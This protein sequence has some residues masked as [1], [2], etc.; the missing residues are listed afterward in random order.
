LGS[1]GFSSIRNEPIAVEDRHTEALGI[2]DLFQDDVA[3]DA[4]RSFKLLFGRKDTGLNNVV[5]EH[6]T[7]Q[8]TV[9][10]ML[11]KTQGVRDSA[12]DLVISVIDMLQPEVLPFPS[13]RRN[14]PVFC[15]P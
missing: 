8:L 14:S 5:V 4:S 9:G 15:L 12:L 6:H 11:R 3:A 10:K 2:L 1:F 7:D 13:R